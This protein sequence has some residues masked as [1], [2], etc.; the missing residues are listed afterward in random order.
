MSKNYNN[1]ISVISLDQGVLYTILIGMNEVNEY[2]SACLLLVSAS[3]WQDSRG[4]CYPESGFLWVLSSYYIFL[5]VHKICN[6]L[7]NDVAIFGKSHFS[8]YGEPLGAIL[9]QRVFSIDS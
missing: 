4:L 8:P 3:S 7:I 9:P 2:S 1:N 6:R 5:K